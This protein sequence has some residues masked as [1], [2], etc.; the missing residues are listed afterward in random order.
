VAQRAI[1]STDEVPELVNDEL[2]VGNPDCVVIPEVVE[3]A[4]MIWSSP[5]MLIAQKLKGSGSV[6]ALFN[7]ILICT[8]MVWFT[9]P[10]VIVKLLR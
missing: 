10:E 6:F 7:G 2:A 5:E 4:T 9:V 3:A 8:V 1:L